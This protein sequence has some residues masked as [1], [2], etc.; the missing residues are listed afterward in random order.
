VNSKFKGIRIILAIAILFAIPV[1]STYTCYY[2]VAAADFLSRNPKFETFDQEFLSAAFEN[3]LKAFVP[4]GYLNGSH[5]ITYPHG[6]ASHFFSKIHSL[7]GETLIL[8]C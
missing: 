1:S 7:N 4:G 6:H 5:V 2:T 8:R 3:E